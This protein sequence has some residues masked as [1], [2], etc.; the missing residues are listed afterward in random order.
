VLDWKD[1]VLALPK[2]PGVRGAT[3][4]GSGQRVQLRKEPN[5]TLVLFPSEERDPIDTVIVLE[6][7]P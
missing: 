6:K 4:L 1:K 7:V 2:L 5:S 3:L